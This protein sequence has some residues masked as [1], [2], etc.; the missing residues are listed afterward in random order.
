MCKRNMGMEY[1][2]IHASFSFQETSESV[3]YQNLDLNMIK[4]L[5]K[6][7]GVKRGRCPRS[8]VEKQSMKRKKFHNASQNQQLEENL[9]SY[10][11]HNIS[12]SQ[13]RFHFNEG[14][15]DD[16]IHPSPFQVTS[17]LHNISNFTPTSISDYLFIIV[18]FVVVVVN[19]DHSRI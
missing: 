12:S 10:G 16:A 17:P 9:T 15:L 19:D 11:I 4:G 14:L 1:N 2:S 13:E 6:R 7:E 8:C 18:F 3:I 5:E